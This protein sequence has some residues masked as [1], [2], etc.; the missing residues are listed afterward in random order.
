MKRLDFWSR[1]EF[2][3]VGK[4]RRAHCCDWQSA[5]TNQLRLG[6][7]AKC[8]MALHPDVPSL[9][10]P[11][12][13]HGSPDAPDPVDF[14]GTT[15]THPRHPRRPQTH[16]HPHAITMNMAATSED[17][18]GQDRCS[19]DGADAFQPNLGAKTS[20]YCGSEVLECS[21]GGET[22]LLH[23]ACIDPWE[24]RQPRT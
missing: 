16:R 21:I 4:R 3:S 1:S 9:S 24:R 5:R 8:P 11:R 19:A 7:T 18:T 15:K 23:R 17:I 2:G 13:F 14:W 20:S 6:R 12:P 22:T 10:M